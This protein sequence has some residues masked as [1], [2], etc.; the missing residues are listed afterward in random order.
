MSLP[1]VS[2]LEPT[3][4]NGCIFLRGHGDRPVRRVVANGADRYG[5]IIHEIGGGRQGQSRRGGPEAAAVNGALLHQHHLPQAGQAA[6]LAAQAV[7]AL[8]QPE[9][10]AVLRVGAGQREP[11][12]ALKALVGGGEGL[13]RVARAA[14]DSH[15]LRRLAGR[16]ELHLV[17]VCCHES[18]CVRERLAHNVKDVP[19]RVI[20]QPLELRLG[21]VIS[22]V[23][24]QHGLVAVLVRRQ[25]R[26]KSSDEARVVKDHKGLVRAAASDV[27]GLKC[28]EYVARR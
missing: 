10:V 20:G 12:R 13:L 27:R 19:R 24:Q 28:L 9:Q 25:Q 4:P 22:R 16:W 2:Q 1:L 5:R 21:A 11:V 3:E 14:E 6:L 15:R 7:V 26:R 8:A 17:H 23:V 18:V